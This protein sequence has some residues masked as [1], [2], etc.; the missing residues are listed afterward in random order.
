MGLSF[1]PFFSN[2]FLSWIYYKCGVT[3]FDLD[4]HTYRNIKNR[5]HEKVSCNI[6][7][8]LDWDER[9]FCRREPKIAKRN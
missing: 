3:N 9:K 4:G 8:E 5:K 6:G 2:T 1:A 7:I